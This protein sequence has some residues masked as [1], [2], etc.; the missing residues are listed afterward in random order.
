[1]VR[2]SGAKIPVMAK[3]AHKHI[4][5]PAT[6]EQISKGVGVTPEDRRIVNKVLRELGFIPDEA[7]RPF[8]KKRLSKQAQ[9]PAEP[10]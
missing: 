5:P 4:A 2:L 8:S 9:S 3:T 7:K 6:A 10:R 1:M